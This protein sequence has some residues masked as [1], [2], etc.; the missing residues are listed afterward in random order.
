M[1]QMKR[2]NDKKYMIVSLFIVVLS[3]AV[4]YA[5]FADTLNIAGTA[6][7]TGSFDVEFL[8]ATFVENGTA[9]GA[10]AIISGDKNTLTLGVTGLNVPGDSVDYT[11]TI[12]NVGN[13]SAEL[14]SV[15][16][17]GTGDT[18]VKAEIVPAFVPGSTLAANGEL[19]FV[20]NV[21]WDDSVPNQGNKDVTYS[22]TLNYQQAV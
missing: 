7:T 14:L 8:S 17:V 11:I 5:I 9:T 15:D 6:Q 18:E 12:K 4:G 16:I 13:I 21:F 19:Q 20:I 22:V 3:L 1:T 10:S 2:K